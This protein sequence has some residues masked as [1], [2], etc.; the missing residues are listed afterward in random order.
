MGDNRRVEQG[1]HKLVHCE[2]QIVLGMGFLA[3]T[4]GLNFEWDGVAWNTNQ[5]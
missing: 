3:Q 1:I 4:L 5:H 2:N